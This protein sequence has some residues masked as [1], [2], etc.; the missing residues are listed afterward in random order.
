MILANIGQLNQRCSR[1][2]LCLNFATKGRTLYECDMLP[3]MLCLAGLSSA[4][5]WFRSVVCMMAMM[6]NSHG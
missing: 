1:K 2:K 6:L 5:G 3:V 4:A